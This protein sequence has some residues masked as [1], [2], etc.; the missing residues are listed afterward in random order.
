[1]KSPS[2]HLF[3]FC[4]LLFS[5]IFIAT[6]QTAQFDWVKSIGSSGGEHVNSFVVNANR[7]LIV[8]G[9]FSGTVDFDAGQGVSNLTSNGRQDIFFAEYDTDGNLIWAKHFGGL[10]DE[11]IEEIKMDKEGNLFITGYFQKTVD[12]DPGPGDYSLTT[13]FTSSFILKLDND[14]NFIWAGPMV[15]GVSVCDIDNEGNIIL[16]GDFSGTKDFDP[17]PGTFMATTAQN[18]FDIFV[19]KL[20]ND[21]NFIWMKQLLNKF[22]P[23]PQEHGLKTDPDNSIILGGNFAGT[24]DFDPG[25]ETNDLASAGSDDAFLLKLDKNGNFIWVRQFGAGGGDKIGAVETDKHGNVF[26]TGAFYNTVDFDPGPSDYFI[27]TITNK[28]SCFVLKLDG[29]GNFVY[30]KNF[31]GESFG[32][33]LTIDSSENLYIAGGLRG[34]VDLDPGP[35]TYMI[36]NKALFN[37]KL[38]ANGNLVW[39]NSFGVHGF[40]SVY[41]TIEV[42]ILK[43]VY[44]ASSFPGTVD[45]DPGPSDY[46]VNSAG[47]WDA[48]ILKQSQCAGTLNIIDVESCSDYEFNGIIYSQIGTY[49]QS[50][51]NTIG[52]DSI[53]QINLTHGDKFNQINITSCDAFIWNGVKLTNTGSYRD[54]FSL[55][56]G[57]DSIVQLDLTITR[58]ITN[59]SETA[60]GSYTWNGMTFDKS[61]TYERTFLLNNGCDSIAILNLTIIEAP[62]PILGGDTT[63]CKGE[64]FTLSP[65][66]FESYLWNSNSTGNTLTVADTG[67]YW[68]TV[69]NAN[70]CTATDTIEVR[71]SSQCVSCDLTLATKIYP[72]PM[73]SVLYIEKNWTSCRVRMNLYNSIGQLVINVGIVD[74]INS[75]DLEKL[76]A[77]VYFYKL[78]S[79]D[80]IL[81]KG[82][83]LKQKK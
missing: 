49:Y 45:F 55:A 20:D 36:S 6:A 65:G 44:Y 77:G 32:Q 59:V 34:A 71:A 31:P 64:T 39:A 52:C 12:F 24:I 66:D 56:S 70:N 50:F 37:V 81:L 61:G 3:A 67:S 26:S 14:G 51:L 1:M 72:N 21:G 53:F 17:G 25:P 83:L 69:T 4:F 62:K 18:R 9:D 79:E 47:G 68:V 58:N 11:G 10:V 57:C 43:N 16:G 33:S 74:G 48:F 2:L 75:I 5:H 35:A 63:F 13:E 41:C 82:K 23:S 8:A 76:A 80:K 42:D 46:I 22:S 19:V 78:Y 40:E 73:V 60:C 15:A 29:D 54:T 38:D 28:R 27:T 7:S 30:V